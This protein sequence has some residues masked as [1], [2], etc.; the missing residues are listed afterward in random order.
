M[1]RR[2]IQR[3]EVVIIRF[4]DRP[5]G[6]GVAEFLKDADNLAP[7]PH[8]RMLGSNWTANAGKRDIDNGVRERSCGRKFELELL[9]GR[10]Y[11]F[12]VNLDLV[13]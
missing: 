4:D 11:I 8:D 5:F 6:N 13:D 12:D 10:D 1:V 3:F 9:S 2:E 7:S